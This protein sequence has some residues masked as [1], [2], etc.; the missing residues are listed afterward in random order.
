MKILIVEDDE[1]VRQLLVEILE[2]QDYGIETATDGQTAWELAQT[3]TYDLILLDVMLP[4]LSGIDF[5]RKLR[6]Q[7]YQVP[8]MLITGRDSSKDRDEGLDAGADDYLVKPFDHDELLARIR[9]LLD[10]DAVTTHILEWSE[11]RLDSSRC[12][13]TY[14]GRPVNLT[15]KEYSLLELLLRSPHHVFSCSAIIQ[16]LWWIEETPGEEVVRTHIKSLQ[17][18][19]TA[20]GAATDLIDALY[21]MG[22]RLKPLEPKQSDNQLPIP[23][24]GIW[25]RFKNKTIAQVEALATMAELFQNTLDESVGAIAEREAHMLAGALGLFGAPQASAIAK[26]IERLLRD[27]QNL[28]ARQITQV[29]ELASALRTEVQQS[30]TTSIGAQTNDGDPLLLIVDRDRSLAEKIVTEA[31]N[32]GIW[33]EI[34]TNLSAARDMM[35]WNPPNVV[36]LDL[37][38]TSTSEN[39]WAFLTDL[40]ER[41]PSV[42]VLVFT[43]Q[44]SLSAR[45]EVALLGA[46]AFLQKP[47]SPTQVLEVI[48]QVLQQ[49]EVEA[50][51]NIMVVDDDPL[52]LVTMRRLLEPWGLKVTTLEDPRRFWEVLET[53]SPDLLVLDIHMPHLSGLELCQIVRNDTRTCGLP[54]LFLTASTDPQLVHQVFAVGGDDFVAKPIVGPEVVTRIINRLERIKLLRNLAE[55]DPLTK[56]SNRHKSTQDLDKFLRLSQRHQ[57]PLCLAILDLDYFKQVNDRYGHDTGDA[58]LRQMGQLLK[59]SFRQEDVVAR[60]GGEEFVIGMYSTGAVDG[61]QRLTKFQAAVR[62]EEFMT[63][64]KLPLPITFSAGIAVYPEDGTDLQ[65]L[66]RA[67][68]QALAVAKLNGRDRIYSAKATH[69]QTG[70]DG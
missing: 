6:N 12:Q 7:G 38:V 46:R 36:L 17:Q 28:S 55:T 33:A 69:K 4:K 58:V 49:N 43:D 9:T 24:T 34:A 52:I 10:R 16:H 59:R 32:Q 66:Y 57:K 40:R 8:I 39:S 65:S 14:N 15:V 29:S 68:D 41:E 2:H 27:R 50:D 51:A 54:I 13:V 60:W 42:P 44:D 23:L 64:D 31:N 1:L 3:V 70:D 11:L 5:C 19:L 62:Q 35:A 21:G 47:V 25:D 26:E 18:K 53:S 20:M 61:M 48:N 67:A 56:V 30:G 45:R 37:S 22:Y 63:V